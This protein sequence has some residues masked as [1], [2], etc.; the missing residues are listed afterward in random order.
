ME[1]GPDLSTVFPQLTASTRWVFLGPHLSLGH[2]ELWKPQLQ[3]SKPLSWK[4]S[5][6]RA[7][8][9]QVVPKCVD[10]LPH[11][12]DANA[13][14]VCVLVTPLTS[15]RASINCCAFNY[16][17][18]HLLLQGSRGLVGG[19][20]QKAL[21][22]VLGLLP[23]VTFPVPCWIISQTEISRRNTGPPYFCEVQGAL[24]H[25]AERTHVGWKG[26][27]RVI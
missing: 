20:S 24:Y 5:C 9:Q 14:Q 4:R 15:F 18:P 13:I 27:Q 2:K 22:R 8:V 17:S 1:D 25:M 19:K 12:A 3:V 26:P 7:K 21:Q 23:R 10:G 11:Y 16:I 6:G